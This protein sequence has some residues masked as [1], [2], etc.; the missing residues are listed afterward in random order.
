MAEDLDGDG[1]ADNRS[2]NMAITSAKMS[3]SHVIIGTRGGDIYE[4]EIPNKPTQSFKTTKFIS[5]HS[6]ST[7]A[8]IASHPKELVY[9]TTGA[10]KTLRIWSTR[11][12]V[13]VDFKKL[14]SA[15]T[16]L[17]FLP[18]TGDDLCRGM[19]SGAVAVLDRKL[20]VVKAFQ[21]STE[22]ITSIKYSPNKKQLINDIAVEG[23]W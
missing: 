19:E 9:A 17:G 6:S 21:H 22:A 10:D 11:R 4:V 2:I 1:E 13:M 15:G 18:V 7:L 12:R 5:A 16:A 20:N 8:S 3:N 14:P 23:S